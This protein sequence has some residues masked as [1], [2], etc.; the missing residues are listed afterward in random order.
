[1][2]DDCRAFLVQG[3]YPAALLAAWDEFKTAQ[4]PPCDDQIR[5]R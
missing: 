3:N 5:P 2:I 1:M 4:S